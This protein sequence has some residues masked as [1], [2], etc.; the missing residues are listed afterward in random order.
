MQ[1]WW[2]IMWYGIDGRSGLLDQLRGEVAE[3]VDYQRRDELSQVRSLGL[4][5]VVDVQWV[6]ER[7][8][9]NPEPGWARNGYRRGP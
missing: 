2:Q 4:G 8:Q 9:R 7:L 6:F 1:V 5:A 3:E